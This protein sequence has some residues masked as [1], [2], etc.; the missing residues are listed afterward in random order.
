MTIFL[1]L[2]HRDFDHLINL[3]D[4]LEDQKIVLHIDKGS[5]ELWSQAHNLGKYQN[6]SLIERRHSVNV[7]WAG[8]SQIQAMLKMMKTA[9]SLMNF[10]EKMVFLSGSDYPIRKKS[11][12]VEK[13]GSQLSVEFLR[14]YKLD[15]R[16]KDLDRWSLYHRWDL[17]YFKNRGTTLNRLNSLLIRFMTNLETFIRGRKKSP[18]FFLYAGSQ[19]FSISK[20]CA[21][22]LMAL[23]DHNFDSFFKTMFAPDEVYF[24]TLFSLSSFSKKNL[25]GGVCTTSH[26]SSRIFQVRNLTYVDESLNKWLDIN[27][28]KALM[29]TN[30]LFA[31]KFDS[32]ISKSLI[33]FLRFRL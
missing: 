31:R 11:E 20:E 21:E 7:R 32:R 22:E 1:I 16:Q 8:F 14:Y 9:T 2:A 12:I 10:G 4:S 29:E 23:R 5:R 3:L 26:E 25:D 27:D 15:D 30:Y 6:L 13:L 33:S 24:H 18:P 19:W 17:R 28:L